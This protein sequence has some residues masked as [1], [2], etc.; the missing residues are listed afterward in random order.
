MLNASNLD[1][2]ANERILAMV[3]DPLAPT[4]IH[5]QRQYSRIDAACGVADLSDVAPSRSAAALKELKRRHMIHINPQTERDRQTVVELPAEG[6][7]AVAAYC[8]RG[9]KLTPVW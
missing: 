2:W 3:R 1:H 5:P 8:Q 7:S 9:C 6:N 4:V